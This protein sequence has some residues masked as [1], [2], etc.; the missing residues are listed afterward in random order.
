MALENLVVQKLILHEVY[1]RRDDKNI[2]PPRYGGQLIQL[3]PDPMDVF[4]QRVTDAM[5]SDSQSMKM[6]ITDAAA[7]SAI[8]IAAA[9]ASANDGK[10]ITESQ[11]F[12][13]RLANVQVARN[14]PGG[15]VVVF[16]GTVGNPARRFVAVIKAE[17]QSGFR[18]ELSRGG[19]VPGHGPARLTW[20]DL[21]TGFRWIVPC[22]CRRPS[23]RTG[24][25]R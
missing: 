21:Q 5:G 2:V 9:L 13:D 17:T 15:V 14:L 3:Q 7:G 24:R 16:T 22:D 18:R 20:P 12:A 1:R 25:H 23:H 4:V 10:F 19:A 11:L 8:E 6:D